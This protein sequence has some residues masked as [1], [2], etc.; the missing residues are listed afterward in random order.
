MVSA[1]LFALAPGTR[2]RL[3]GLVLLNLAITATYVGQGVLIAQVL[4]GVF[5]RRPVASLLAPLAV[6]AAAVAA[7]AALIVVRDAGAVRAAGHVKRAVRQ[8]VVAAL[9]AL[10]PGWLQRTRSGKVQSTVVDAVE[11]IEPYVGR[12]LP[13]AWAAAIGF[14]AV[15]GYLV[16]LDPLVGAVVLGCGLLGPAVPWVARG[17]WDVHGKAWWARYHQMYS[18]ILDAVRG[19]ATL[20]AFN[21]T[22]RTGRELADGA[23]A[24]CRDSIRV[25][26][27]EGV[28][29]GA[30][31]LLTGV[32]TAVAVGLGAVRLAGGAVTG[33]ELL[34]ILLLT[35]EAFRPLLDLDKAY[36]A[37]YAA[38]PSARTVF[39]LLDQQDHA[40][41]VPTARTAP[42]IAVP[43]SVAFDQVTFR[44]RDD[45]ARPA[46][47]GFSL[48]I[49]AGERVAVVGRSG[50]GKTTLVSL[51][52]RLFDPQQGRVLIDGH[53]TRELPVDLLRSLVAVVAQ[54]THLFHDTV[55]ANLLLARPDADEGDL[56]A[57]VAAARAR[58]VVRALPDGYDTVVG[59]RG[60]KLSGG[61]RQRIAIARAL[62]KDAPILVLDE[63][64][65]SVDAANEAAIQE[66]LDALTV[67]RTTLVIAHRLSTVRTADRVVVVDA[68]RIVESGNHDE[69]LSSR[70]AYAR[71]VASQG[72]AR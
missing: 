51:L 41:A 28:F 3:A 37:S 43:P 46:L 57:A 35:R 59:E 39:D 1:R 67:G 8:R 48:R 68:G 25:N 15:A 22:R 58:D 34:T 21:A 16:V 26:T 7:R 30:L 27:A 5:D 66:A 44:Y 14:A 63:A 23:Q 36:H 11:R 33:G 32:G 69:L 20:K 53:D 29:I 2:L 54:D 31:A 19:M 38:W 61:Q 70:G 4:A 18:E 49:E 12:F 50:S 17:Y 65:S 6:V 9:L 24:F 52:L 40:P 71:L 72:G 42:A 10:G 64:T 62:L 13:Q 56:D 47:D 60:Q 45:A 55:R